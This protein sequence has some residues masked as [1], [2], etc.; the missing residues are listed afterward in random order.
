MITEFKSF[1]CMFCG[2]SVDLRSAAGLTRQIYETETPIEVPAYVQV[3][4]CNKCL[5][6]FVRPEDGENMDRAAREQY[7][8][9]RAQEELNSNIQEI[10]EKYHLKSGE[11]KNML[12]D[13]LNK[14]EN[15]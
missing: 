8:Y 10:S 13:I 4:R 11:V 2:G 15:K 5:E 7:F 6:I 1:K 9:I 14:L 12:N 3:P